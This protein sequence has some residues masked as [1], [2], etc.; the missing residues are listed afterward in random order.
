VLAKASSKLPDQERNRQSEFSQPAS[1]ELMGYEF[2][3]G[4]ITQ[5]ILNK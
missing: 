1:E 2:L 4:A 5:R 3:V